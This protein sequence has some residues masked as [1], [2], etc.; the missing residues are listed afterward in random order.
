MV[1]LTLIVILPFFKP[2][3]MH[4]HNVA[5]FHFASGVHGSFTLIMAWVFISTWSA[6]AMEAAAC[7]IGECNDPAR[8]AKI[9]L[10]AEGLYG[11]AMF[12]LIPLMFVVVLGSPSRAPTRSRCSPRSPTRSSAAGHT[13]SGSSASRSSSR[14]CCPR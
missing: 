5:G 3:K 2:S 6:L 1:P 8:D 4:W 14:C 13:S 12:T 7:Y 9:S 11:L 10:T